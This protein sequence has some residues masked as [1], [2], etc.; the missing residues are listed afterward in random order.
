MITKT[1]IKIM[2]GVTLGVQVLATFILIVGI[3][4]QGSIKRL[5]SFSDEIIE[6]FV[7][8][9]NLVITAFSLL[10]FA[11]ILLI[12]VNWT[13]GKGIIISGIVIAS[14]F[15]VNRFGATLP[16]V[17]ENKIAASHGMV[18]IASLSALTSALSLI[19]NSL[20]TIVIAGIFFTCG[21]CVCRGIQTKNK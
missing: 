21:M 10:C 19:I 7:M 3:I 12:L 1:P 16:M 14:A 15:L 18:Y 5:V 17:I 9:W 11:V 13:D 8:P 6:T 20:T 4:F 2:A